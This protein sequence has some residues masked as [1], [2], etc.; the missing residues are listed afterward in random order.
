MR[1][2][3]AQ[4]GLDRGRG[5]ARRQHNTGSA[6]GP[7]SAHEALAVTTAWHQC[8]CGEAWG[9]GG[10]GGKRRW[11]EVTRVNTRHV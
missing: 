3:D 10:C 11:R 5:L 8:N 9:Q 6:K 1:A 4:S 2:E 7:E